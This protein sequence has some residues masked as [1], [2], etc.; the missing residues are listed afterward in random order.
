MPEKKF[1]TMFPV[2]LSKKVFTTYVNS[3]TERYL[4]LIFCFFIRYGH[5]GNHQRDEI[6]ENN[7]GI[8]LLILPFGNH[9]MEKVKAYSIFEE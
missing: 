8:D 4:I 2:S 9:A 5:A 6:K 1:D 7:L 3:V